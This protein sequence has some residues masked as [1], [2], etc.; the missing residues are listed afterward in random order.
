MINTVWNLAP[1]ELR[2][3]TSK[4]LYEVYIMI[5]IV[6]I[7][8]D[9]TS[10]AKTVYRIY[11]M[12]S[13]RVTWANSADPDQTDPKDQFGLCFL[14]FVIRSFSTFLAPEGLLNLR[15]MVKSWGIRIF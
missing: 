7:I 15:N 6:V 12:Y 13:G 11:F 9:Y 4:Y 5:S 2:V 8:C 3:K 1:K 14:L 10:T